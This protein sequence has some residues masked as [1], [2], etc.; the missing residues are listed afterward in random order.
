MHEDE[1]AHWDVAITL[2]HSK[3]FENTR[4]LTLRS[5]IILMIMNVVSKYF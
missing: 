1:G 4:M 5:C 2:L 3:M